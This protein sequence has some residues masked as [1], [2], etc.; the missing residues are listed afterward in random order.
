[1]IDIRALPP[2]TGDAALLQRMFSALIDNALKF[3]GEAAPRIEITAERMGDEWTVCITD[4]GIGFEPE[5]AEKIFE[6]FARLHRRE[7]YPGSGIG[8]ALVRDIADRH[9]G[10]VWARSAAGSGSRFHVALPAR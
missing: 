9:R 2:V 6:M 5:Y 8:L 4:N 7:A 1:M 3:R 10:R